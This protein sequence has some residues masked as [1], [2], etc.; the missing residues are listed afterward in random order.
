MAAISHS[1]KDRAYHREAYPFLFDALQHA[2]EDLG[3]DGRSTTTG[4][5]SGPELLEGVKSLAL[6]RFGLMARTV[7]NQWKIYST[8][9]FGKMVFELIEAGEMRKTP[10]DQLEDFVDVYNFV[11]VFD[12]QYELDTRNAI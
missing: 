12:H 10:D 9:D 6:E 8:A 2:Q 3:R 4:H 1:P 7:L 5:V 11:D